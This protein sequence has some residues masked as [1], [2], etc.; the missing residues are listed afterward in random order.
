[1]TLRPERILDNHALAH[2]EC[3]ALDD[4]KGRPN[5]VVVA[6]LT[7]RLSAT[8]IASL[9]LEPRPIRMTT[10]WSGAAGGAV[11]FP[12]DRVTAKVGTD[13]LLLASAHPPPRPLE[14]RPPSAID[15]RLRLE[16]GRR[17]LT[18]AVRV[19]G[20]RVFTKMLLGVEPGP[21]EPILGPVPL[22]YELAEGG[23]DA[24][25]EPAKREHPDNPAGVGYRATGPRVGAEAHR[26]EPLD[27]RAP[28]GFGPTAPHWPR[29]RALYGTTD[30][31]YY[32]HRYPVAPL[33]F[34]PLHTS[35]AHPDLW[36]PEP[37]RGDE[38]IE[39]L[40]VVPEGAFRF[41]LPHYAPRFDV[42]V[43]GEVRPVETH[44]D[45]FLIDLRDPDERLVELT[46]RVAVPL[47]K[48]TDRLRSIRITHATELPEDVYPELRRRL[49]ARRR[50]K[51]NRA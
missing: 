18:K 32:R 2:A 44:L 5:A 20:R 7:W 42:D 40:G 35:D 46:W 8:G 6:R 38:P 34:N 9:A 3:F 26:L 21:A 47:P 23:T 51:E 39:L 1:M 45:T 36:S 50:A 30:E 41:R 4:P 14:A 43:D 16:A 13:V 12:S 11:L 49:D 10:T 24:D 28:A 48:K 27:G 17:T 15:V 31:R 29:R 33:D 25:A 19:H 22:G 37:L